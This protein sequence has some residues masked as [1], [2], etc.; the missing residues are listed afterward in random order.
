VL[1]VNCLLC[2]NRNRMGPGGPKTSTIIWMILCRSDP[3]GVEAEVLM[4]QSSEANGNGNCCSCSREYLSRE[5]IFCSAVYNFESY[6]ICIMILKLSSIAA[7]AVI[8]L[9]PVTAFTLGHGTM[10]GFGSSLT[11]ICRHPEAN[12]QSR[13]IHSSCM[14]FVLWSSEINFDDTEDSDLQLRK[15]ALE[16]LDCITSPKDVD[17]PGYDVEKDMRREEIL[18]NND[19]SALKIELRARGLRQNG[20]KMEMIAR[21]LLHIIDPKINYSQM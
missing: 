7:T 5:I 1:S 13:R 3:I 2:R 19:H 11:K 4:D 6:A 9:N 8:V 10:M 20:D 16:L 21:L 17:D 14:N 18:L 15:D 12:F